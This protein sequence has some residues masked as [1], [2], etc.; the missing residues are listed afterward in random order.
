MENT[1]EVK[2]INGMK[3]TIHYIDRPIR[4][5]DSVGGAIGSLIN[6]VETITEIIEYVYKPSEESTIM[7]YPLTPDE[8]YDP[9]LKV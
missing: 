3:H 1:T 7:Q 6:G 8:V 5:G 4:K 9:N 2:I